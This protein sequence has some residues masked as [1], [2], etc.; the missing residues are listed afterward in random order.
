MNKYLNLRLHVGTE[1]RRHVQNG[2][3]GPSF[4]LLI[5]TKQMKFVRQKKQLLFILVVERIN[6]KS[7]HIRKEQRHALQMSTIV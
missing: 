7:N 4:R 1:L 6:L 3:Q 2:R 5:M